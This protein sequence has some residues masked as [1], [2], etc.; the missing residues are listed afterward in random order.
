[1]LT[2]VAQ[3]WWDNLLVIKRNDYADRVPW[4]E[5]KGEF[6]KNFRSEAEVERLKTEFL[7]THQG[8]MDLKTFRAHFI[9]RLQFN[10]EYVNNEASKCR[11]FH[12]LLRDEIRI[13]I[14]VSQFKSFVD[15]FDAARDFEDEL[16]REGRYTW[17]KESY[18][19]K[20]KLEQGGLP[21]KKIKGGDGKKGGVVFP[22]VCFN[23]GKPGHLAKDC[24]VEVSK[25]IICYNYNGEGHRKAECP[26]L[27]DAARK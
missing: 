3:R 6:F 2:G 12:R 8:S 19:P 15:L 9:D 24:G 16:I 11:L 4:E 18:T 5:F 17:K 20:R 23:C 21:N 22:R 10:P 7:N 25:D 14:S 27:S 13:K 1:M 26:F